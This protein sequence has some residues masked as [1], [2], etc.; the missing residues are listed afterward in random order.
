[1][2]TSSSAYAPGLTQGSVSPPDRASRLR[3]ASTRS[4]AG[5]QL[6][7]KLYSLGIQAALTVLLSIFGLGPA[8]GQA[9][10]RDMVLGANTQ[11]NRDR[12]VSEIR[13][14]RADG[15]IRR[16]SPVLL[17]LPSRTPRKGIRFA[18]LSTHPAGSGTAAFVK[19]ESSF[20]LSEST[21]VPP[22]AAE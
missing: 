15:T 22:A 20:L 5:E 12:V 10:D 6:S 13:Q 14:A 18:P 4:F 3:H 19:S 7:V 11:A 8:M 2:P 9:I 1:M 17:E 16:W 21:H